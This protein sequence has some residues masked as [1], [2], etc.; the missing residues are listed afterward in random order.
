ML[1]FIKFRGMKFRWLTQGREVYL[2]ISWYS[3]SCLPHTKVQRAFCIIS[4]TVS[5]LI[6]PLSHYQNRKQKSSLGLSNFYNTSYL[7][8]IL[9]FFQVLS[10]T[11]LPFI[12]TPKTLPMGISYELKALPM[13]LGHLRS[14]FSCCWVTLN[15]L[16]GR[17]LCLGCPILKRKIN[18][19]FHTT[20]LL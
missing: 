11:W 13:H 20:N 16:H 18:D 7:S 4:S 9:C 1:C 10:Y 12:W 15:K 14:T 19:S 17:F 6:I 5:S 8:S 3:Q 2:L